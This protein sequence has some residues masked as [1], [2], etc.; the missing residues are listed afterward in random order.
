[1]SLDSSI[2]LFL[3]LPIIIIT[4]ALLG[5]KARNVFLFI[6]NILLYAFAEPIFILLLFGLM[7]VNFAFGIYSSKNKSVNPK[8][9]KTLF[10]I[11]LCLN[12]SMLVF[13]KYIAF[14]GG[15]L[16]SIIGWVG[17]A[18]TRIIRVALPV[19]ISFYTFQAVSYLADVYTEKCAPATNFIKFGVYYSCFAQ[20]TAGPIVRYRDVQSELDDR[21]VDLDGIASGLKRFLIGL[22]QKII[23]ATYLSKIANQVFST[24]TSALG[25]FSAWVGIIFYALQIYFDFAGYSSMAIGIAKMLGFNYKENFNHPYVSD[26]ITDFWRRWHISL[27]TWFRDYVYFSLGGNRKGKFRMYLGL[28]LVFV[29]SGI[30][31]GA[32]GTFFVWGLY[33]AIFIMLEKTPFMKR[34]LSKLPKP[35]KHVYAMLIVL[36][37]WVFFRAP[38]L[39]Y[40]FGY[41]GSMLFIHGASTGLPTMSIAMTIVFV[42][43]VIGSMPIF[44]RLGALIEQ[45][46]NNTI[47]NVAYAITWIILIALFALCVP[48][49]FS[50]SATPFIYTQF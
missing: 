30:W 19:G 43:S 32:N 15:I 29:L 45:K 9:V 47:T 3:A 17:I 11:C 44:N 12:L 40:A 23:L 39:S 46:K 6:I 49:I 1:M 5:K 50:G 34:F 2:F 36:I 48:I 26:S 33:H 38:T 7:G 20:I 42:I 10:I 41:L 37:G 28:F 35:L 21:T 22:S 14:L 13:L 25:G 16:N 31:H 18:P 8:R 24:Q 4:N 27:S